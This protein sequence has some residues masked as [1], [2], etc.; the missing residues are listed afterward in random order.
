MGGNG[1]WGK[2]GQK[3]QEIAKQG[4]W[5]SWAG[6]Q[7]ERRDWKE[8]ERRMWRG[9]ERRKADRK[10]E[11]EEIGKREEYGRWGEKREW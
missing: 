6:S 10:R 11:Q 9:L 5:K 3:K 7:E 2:R 8:R 4:E 1:K